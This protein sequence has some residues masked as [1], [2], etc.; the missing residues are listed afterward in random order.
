[1][2]NFFA[3]IREVYICQNILWQVLAVVLTYGIVASGFDWYYYTHTRGALLQSWLFPAAIIGG[4]V[5][6]LLPILL[7]IVGK[8]RA[9]ARLVSTAFAVAQAAIL[10]LAIS[11][12]YKVFTGRIPPPFRTNSL[13]D[14]SNQFH[15]GFLREGAFWGWPSSHT[16]VAFAVAV[17]L[18]ILYAKRPLV[19][20][21]ALLIA[22]YVGIGVSTN[23]HWFSEF[24]AGAIIGSIIGSA[25]G[26]SFTKRFAILSTVT[27]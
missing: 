21:G 11:S 6:I 9:R 3:T 25:V 26:T 4:L 27:T 14:I 19:Q 22:L 15:F 17:T 7:Y 13:V 5:P 18:F 24:V 1:V 10:G 8:A 20:Y 23:I 16:T 12:F 2:K